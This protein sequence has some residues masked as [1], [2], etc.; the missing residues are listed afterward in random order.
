M[1]KRVI[2]ILLF[3][4]IAFCGC[5]RKVYSACI[6]HPLDKVAN[7]ELLDT[8]DHKK[9]VIYTLSES[10][11]PLFLDRL[12]EIEFYRC[13][14]D[15]PTDLGILAIRITYNDGYYDEIGTDIN[16][17]YN[18]EGDGQRAGWYYVG[19]RADFTTLFSCY[20][21]ESTLPTIDK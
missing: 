7:I 9:T 3:I 2:C 19:D 6:N 8:H 11:I 20:V 17:Y 16:G 10:E 12:L 18:A 5:E 21:E 1:R 14:N 13:F 4:C 15:P